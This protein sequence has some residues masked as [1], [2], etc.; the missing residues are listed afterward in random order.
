MGLTS[1][2][3]CGSVRLTR[4]HLIVVANPASSAVTLPVVASALR[5]LAVCDAIA[6]ATPAVSVARPLVRA[7]QILAQTNR[8]GVRTWWANTAMHCRCNG[9][10]GRGSGA[11]WMCESGASQQEKA[12]DGEKETAKLPSMEAHLRKLYMRV[13]P[14]LFSSHPEARDENEKSFQLLSEFLSA[15][16]NQGGGRGGVGKAFKLNFNMRPQAEPGEGNEGGAVAADLEKVTV[17]IRADGSPRDKKNQLKKLFE[18]CGIFGDFTYSAAGGVGGGGGNGGHTAGPASDL[19]NFVREQSQSAAAAR[20]EHDR[21]WRQVFAA[22]HALQLWHQ[23][24]V[25]FAGECAKWSPDARAALLQHVL[26]EDVL[27]SLARDSSE[28]ENASL[29]ASQNVVIGDSNSINPEGR[30]TLD[31]KVRALSVLCVCV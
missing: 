29:Q 13:H 15:V 16:K 6:H 8:G 14:D 9:G 7:A 27:A 3:R 19:E 11:R 31:A 28:E 2:T 5:T 12:Q 1:I 10:Q 30:V 24:R 20:Q 18:A 23:I 25:S 4:K 17:S 21:S 26:S 22:Q